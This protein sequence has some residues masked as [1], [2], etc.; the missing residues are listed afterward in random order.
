MLEHCWVSPATGD[1]SMYCTQTL[2]LKTQ[3]LF[4]FLVNRMLVAMGAKLFQLQAVGCI[5]SVLGGG[6]TGYPWRSLIRIA[7]AFRAL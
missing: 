5:A 7:S 3:N 2:A 1:A 4:N 6:V